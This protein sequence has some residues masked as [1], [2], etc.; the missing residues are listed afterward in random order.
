ML[1]CLRPALCRAFAFW[2]L[3]FSWPLSAAGADCEARQPLQ[4]LP[5]AAVTDGDTLRP[6]QGPALRLIGV[7]TPELRA[8]AASERMRARAAR[9]FLQHRLPE[10]RVYVHED[11]RAEDRYRR[12]LVHAFTADGRLLAAELLAAGHGFLVL[13]PPNLAYAACLIAAQ[14]QARAAGLGVWADPAFGPLAAD[15]VTELRPGFLRLQGRVVGIEASATAWWIRLHGDAVLRIAAADWPLFA[16]KDPAS[17]QERTVEASGWL[18]DRGEQP[19]PR[20]RWLMPVGHPAQLR[21]LP[22]TAR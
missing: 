10:G 4:V 1:I 14:A 15:R 17:W 2:L 11:V 7:N 5:L 6:Q 18:V 13:M 21:L 12:R 9:R 22:D 16:G 8:E 19:Q 20:A 3:C